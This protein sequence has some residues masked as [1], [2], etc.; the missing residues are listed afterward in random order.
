MDVATA[1]LVESRLRA[2]TLRLDDL[3][4]VLCPELN[5]RRRV[6][7][8]V[9][10]ELKYGRL[11][12]RA[13]LNNLDLI[14]EIRLSGVSQVVVPVLRDS[15]EVGVSLLQL[16]RQIRP[17][18]LLE[19]DFVV[20]A[21]LAG[22]G[23]CQGQARQ[24][25]EQDGGDQRFMREHTD[26]PLNYCCWPTSCWPSLA[27]PLPSPLLNRP[28]VCLARPSGYRLFDVAKAAFRRMA[29]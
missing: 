21:G 17:P 16:A 25:A 2:V 8:I 23:L 26:T 4:N 14:V 15:R 9:I 13:A 11:V 6:P 22:D 29:A 24:R 1:L 27:H 18:A 3:G 12:G 5:D 28:I 10:A 7:V 20:I 19:D